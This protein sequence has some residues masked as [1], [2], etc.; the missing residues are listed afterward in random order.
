MAFAVAY[1]PS[2]LSSVLGVLLLGVVGPVLVE[3]FGWYSC[4][5]RKQ[6][7]CFNIPSLKLTCSHLNMGRNPKRKGSSSNVF[8]FQG[9]KMLV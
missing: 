4:P 8:H 3:R 2:E 7:D 1:L 5:V 9:A 6:V